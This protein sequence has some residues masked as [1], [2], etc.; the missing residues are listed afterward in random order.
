MP[1]CREKGDAQTAAVS[2]TSAEE[3]ALYLHIN[4]ALKAALGLGLHQPVAV[5]RRTRRLRTI[6]TCDFP[7]LTVQLVVM[8]CDDSAL[9]RKH[10]QTSGFTLRF[11]LLT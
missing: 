8:T 5:H 7:L 4:T 1:N 6:R 11:E 3:A 2:L 9:V 10:D